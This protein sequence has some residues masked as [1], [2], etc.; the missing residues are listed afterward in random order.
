MPKRV[1]YKDFD[2]IVIKEH[3]IVLFGVNVR[4]KSSVGHLDSVAEERSNIS[5]K[6]ELIYSR[7]IESVIQQ[8]RALY[9]QF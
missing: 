3:S 8:S 6:K 4:S 7:A 9:F 1:F 5:E 2:H